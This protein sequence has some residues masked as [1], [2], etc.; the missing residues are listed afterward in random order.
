M[1]I[2]CPKC[3]TPFA[4]DEADYATI[5]SQVRNQEPIHPFANLDYARAQAKKIKRIFCIILIIFFGIPFILGI[6]LAVSGPF[7]EV[8]R[9]EKQEAQ[10]LE[11]QRQKLLEQQAYDAEVIAVSGIDTIAQKDR[12]FSVRV[13]E[14]VPYELNYDHNRANWGSGLF[15]DPYLLPNEHR[16]AI[17]IKLVN[18]KENTVLYGNPSNYVKLFIDDENAGRIVIQDNDF[19]NGSNDDNYFSGGRMISGHVFSDNYGKKL[20]KQQTMSWW[21]PVVVNEKS[22]KLIL[23]FDHN[24]SITIDNP[25]AGNP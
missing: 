19:L 16:V 22:E 14:V 17:H 5:V 24:M 9:R 15:D 3:G 10:L 8:K 13:L 7:H 21:V 25:C 18:F 12:Y 20:E 11:E 2:K 4:I 1:E 23:H 6:I